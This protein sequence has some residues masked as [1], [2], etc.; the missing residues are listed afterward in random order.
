MRITNNIGSS[1]PLPPPQEESKSKASSLSSQPPSGNTPDLQAL[2]HEIEQHC[3][4]ADQEAKNPNND[5]FGIYRRA[6][7]FEGD[8]NRYINSLPPPLDQDEALQD[9]LKLIRK[10]IG[11]FEGIHDDQGLYKQVMAGQLHQIQQALRRVSL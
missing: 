8:L 10:V 4:L 2:I 9:A 6:I 7:D 11:V 5:G 3:K 1:A